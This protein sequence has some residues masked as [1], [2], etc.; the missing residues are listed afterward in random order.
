MTV[1]DVVLFAHITAAILVFVSLTVD[2][3]AVAGLRGTWTAEQGR[4]W[5]RTL[6][7]SAAFGVGAPGAPAEVAA[8]AGNS[9]RVLHDTYL[10]CI[11]SHDDRV[12]KRIEDALDADS[13]IALSSQCVKASGMRTVGTTRDPVRYLSVNRPPK[14]AYSPRPPGPADSHDHLQTPAFTGVFTGQRAYN[15]VATEPGRRPDPAHV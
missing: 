12:S 15:R 2:W 13:T 5:V 14:P 3:L 4:P 7:V 10:R 11:D 8:R 6:D 9:T 1:Y